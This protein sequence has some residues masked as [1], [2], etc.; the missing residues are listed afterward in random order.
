LLP[1]PIS[2]TFDKSVSFW[3]YQHP[4]PPSPI[5]P[6]SWAQSINKNALYCLQIFCVSIKFGVSES[7]E[8]NPSVTTSIALLGSLYLVFRKVYTM[9]S[10]SRCPNLVTF[11]VAAYAP[12]CKQLCDKLSMM[13]WSYYLINPLITPKPANHPA[14]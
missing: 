10:W 6:K 14:E 1:V 2:K 8:N 3:I 13:T 11:F 12:S 4:F 5:Q 7:I 9:A